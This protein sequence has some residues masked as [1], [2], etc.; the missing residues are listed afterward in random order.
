MAISK[1]LC[2]GAGKML[3]VI[4]N[5]SGLGASFWEK[6]VILM[7]RAYEI[8]LV[9]NAC[10]SAQGKA[11]WYND[12]WCK[13]SSALFCSQPAAW[14][15]W[16]IS[17]HPGAWEKVALKQTYFFINIPEDEK[18]TIVLFKF[19]LNMTFLHERAVSHIQ[20]TLSVRSRSNLL[21]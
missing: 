14:P 3:C 20:V 11:S 13:Y 15:F 8:I 12:V 5:C 6:P 18:K 2:A 16:C 1:F 10:S 4:P 19:K 7:R 9:R 21:C 17:H